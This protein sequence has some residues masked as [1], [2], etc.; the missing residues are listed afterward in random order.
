MAAMTSNILASLGLGVNQSAASA[1]L[2]S[3]REPDH[4]RIAN[5]PL[6]V[7]ICSSPRHTPPD[8]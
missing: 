7:A 5:T 1:P 6:I 4:R 8:V 3:L 2:R